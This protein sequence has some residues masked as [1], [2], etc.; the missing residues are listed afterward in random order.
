MS[1]Q[2][3]K[4][5]LLMKYGNSDHVMT[6][7]RKEIKTWTIINSSDAK[8]CQ[9]FHN[10]LR[11]GEG[12]TQSAKLSQLDTP[13]ICMLLTKL[14]GHTRDKWARHVLSI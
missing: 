13:V 12:I 11:M 9:R 8:G 5:I 6:E 14:P 2:H 3:A 10:F 1:Y 7:Y 4:R